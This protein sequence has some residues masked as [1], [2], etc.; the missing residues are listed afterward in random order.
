[1]TVSTSLPW[2]LRW[3]LIAIMLGFCAAIALW[4]FEFG[5][6]LALDGSSR[7]E[8]ARLRTELEV[9][10]KELD[11]LKVERDKARAV[12]NTADTLVTGNQAFTFNGTTA[13]GTGTVWLGVSGT[14]TLLYVN[15]DGDTAADM[16]VRINDGAVLHTAYAA[17]DFI[18]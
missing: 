17:G 7:E 9:A 8:L 14:Q 12:A 13:G 18:L 11:T 5:R 16:I 10:K 2:P 6:D 1:M 3:A 4:A 15:N